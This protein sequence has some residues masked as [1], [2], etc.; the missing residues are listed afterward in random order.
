M[1]HTHDRGPLAVN[2]HLWP[3]CNLRCRFCYATFPTARA[4][5]PLAQ[6]LRLLD[7]LAAA[8]SDKI[9]FVGGEP[10]LHPH[11]P[12]LLRH[13]DG[14]GLT[15]C[16]VTNGARLT[17][18]LDAAG[19]S[20]HWV[21]LSIDSG[22][23]ATQAA[24]GRGA[25]EHIARAVAHA[26]EARRRGIRLK[27]NTVVTALN[28]RE[29]MSALVRA[30]APDR[31]KVFQVLEIEGEN[32]GKIEDLKIDARQFAAFVDRH[33]HLGDTGMAPIAED[34]DAMRGSYVMIDPQGCFFGNATGRVVTSEPILRV[35]VAAALS[36][37][38]Y[39]DA[40]FHERGGLYDWRG[41]AREAEK[42]RTRHPI[43]AIEGLDG[44]G[45][46]TT[47]EH[48]AALL[49]ARIIR[50]PPAELAHERPA[51]DAMDPDSKRAWYLRGNRL[52]MEQARASQD[53]P[54]VL[55]RSIASTLAFGAA[56]RGRVATGADIPEGFPMPDAVVVLTVPEHMRRARHAG[57]GDAATTEESQLAS[58]P[59]FRQ[60]VIDGYRNLATDVVDASAS[61]EAVAEVVLAVVRR[62]VAA[63]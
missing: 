37:V 27:L 42:R 17:E 32:D 45:K 39:D 3:K 14:L 59:E 57:R 25:G 63:S 16:I 56:E 62:L 24:L 53:C 18:V 50:N 9:T 34:N 23:E 47:V 38:G 4:V 41:G 51:V 10:T 20:V 11:L 44:S 48:V 28:W 21:G 8:G 26:A 58:D 7:L 22:D 40:K 30:V 60:R 52:A 33:Q 46:S 12:E 2:F 15:T 35:G 1:S 31:W 49:G 6:A 13:A 19:S 5:L 54:V 55:D 61:V 36:Q 29:D 43:V